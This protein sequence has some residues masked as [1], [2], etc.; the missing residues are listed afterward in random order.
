MSGGGCGSRFAWA[1]PARPLP[2]GLVGGGSR[3]GTSP[4][5]LA[6][7]RVLE[8][9]SGTGLC[10][11]A[12]ACL[13]ARV[14][15]T[16]RGPALCTLRRNAEANGAMLAAAGGAA[17]VAELDWDDAAAGRGV[18]GAD[19]PYDLVLGADLVY[20]DAGLSSLRGVLTAV[21]SAR[22][23]PAPRL[24]YAHKARHDDLDARVLSMLAE[25]GLSRRVVARDPGQRVTIYA[26]HRQQA[27]PA[28]GH[29][30]TA[31][32]PSPASLHGQTSP[33]LSFAFRRVE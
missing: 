23:T 14:T 29:D 11:L 9:G 26:C 10:G 4:G 24:L 8:L 19:E 3:V 21:F 30:V 6:R 31:V 22:D 13:G 25:V 1:D 12:A 18:L 7:L 16:D 5:P 17:A 33:A 28:V 27:V 32:N 2:T 20:N 15:L